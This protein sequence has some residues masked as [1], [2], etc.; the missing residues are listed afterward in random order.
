MSSV[1]KSLFSPFP[2]PFL[3]HS[4][5]PP[6]ST[7]LRT[8]CLDAC[9]YG[10]IVQPLL[11]PPC[12]CLKRHEIWS[13]SLKIWTK[14]KTTSAP[15]QEVAVPCLFFSSQPTAQRM[16]CIVVQARW[17]CAS[18]HHKMASQKEKERVKIESSLLLIFR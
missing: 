10:C 14:R 13:F 11:M 18:T 8:G 16:N 3:L 12:C 9:P 7:G 4:T 2:F 5:P 15:S 17:S 1:S 6:T